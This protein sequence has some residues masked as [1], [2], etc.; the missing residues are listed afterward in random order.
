MNNETFKI[1]IEVVVGSKNK[2]QLSNLTKSVKE[3]SK[4]S[5]ETTQSID[6]MNAS[7]SQLK[8]MSFSNVVSAISGSSK[9][10]NR[11]G[12]EL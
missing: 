8:N 10:I 5:G 7:L 3:T 9:N 4:A 11:I 6:K 1:D 2:Q 12:R